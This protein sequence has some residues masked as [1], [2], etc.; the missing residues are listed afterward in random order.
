VW[1]GLGAWEINDRRIGGGGMAVRHFG[2]VL[3]RPQT[4]FSMLLSRRQTIPGS[5]DEPEEGRD[6]VSDNTLTLA[7]H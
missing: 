6:R 5:P 7:E 1:R 2:G 3:T 4:T